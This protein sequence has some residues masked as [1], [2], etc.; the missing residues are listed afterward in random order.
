MDL[1]HLTSWAV[2]PPDVGAIPYYVRVPAVRGVADSARE[3]NGT[4]GL[5]RSLDSGRFQ[6]WLVCSSS[7]AGR[8]FA[9]YCKMRLLHSAL[10]THRGTNN[11][12]RKTRQ[13]GTPS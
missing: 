8:G 10:H 12:L 5:T 11:V 6:L 2:S 7:A 3:D 13:Q 4:V 1:A 9:S